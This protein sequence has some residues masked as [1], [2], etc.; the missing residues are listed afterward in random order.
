MLIPFLS[1]SATVTISLFVY[2]RINSASNGDGLLVTLVM[3]I[4]I[5]TLSVLLVICDRIQRKITMEDPVQEILDAT[6]KISSGDFSIRL[7]SSHIYD[8]YNN[9][10]LIKDNLNK[11]VAELEKSEIL[12]NNFV[13]NISHEIKTPLAIIQ[14]YIVLLQGDLDEETKNKYIQTVTSATKRLNNLVTNALKLNKLE[15]QELNLECEKIRLHDMLSETVISF[16]EIIDKKHID[17][18]CYFDEV[19]IVSS[20]SS[21]ELVWNNLLSNAVK[22]TD[23]GGKIT[24]KLYRE[25]KNAVVEVADTG[26]GISP[27]TGAHIFDKFYQGD[28][29]H[30]CEGNG[31]GL[32]LVKKV[33]DVIGGEISV[34]SELG[35]GSTFKVVL[36]EMDE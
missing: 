24:V 23:D 9:Y 21:L 35:K 25:G 28:T 26:C 34:I 11:M 13:S 31:L 6:Q 32:S 19:E 17:I 36:K 22:F 33:I 30:S 16:E 12:K 10:D 27:E 7:E 14:N 18:Q 15:H 3:L 8:K 2:I 29:S 5:V 4:T 20:Y 1:V